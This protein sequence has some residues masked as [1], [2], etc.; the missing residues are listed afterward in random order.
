[1][2]TDQIEDDQLDDVEPEVNLADGS[3]SGDE[4]PPKLDL[5]VEI[6]SPSACERHITV[7]ISREDIKRY[8]DDAFSEMMATAA[9]PGFRTGRAP[10]KVVEG[11]FRQDVTEQ[12]KGSL[13]MDSLSQISEEQKLAAIGEPDLDLSAVEVPQ[14]GPMTFEF[15]LEVRPDFEVPDWKGLELRRPSHDFTEKDIDEQLDQMLARFGQLVPYDGEVGEGHYLTVNITSTS[16]GKQVASEQE[17]I[18][19]MLGDK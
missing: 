12:I 11:R 3:G 14:E 18:G 17:Q 16:D 6:Q 5:V 15:R 13:L 9:V 1:M 2:S 8:L 10:R 7:T 4:T 19:C